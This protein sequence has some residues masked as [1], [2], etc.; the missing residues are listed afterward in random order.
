[1][2]N[3]L[4]PVKLGP[5]KGEEYRLARDSPG[6]YGD[7]RDRLLAGR[8][9]QELAI[10]DR[11]ELAES[12]IVHIHNSIFDPR[13]Y[14]NRVAQ[15]R[16]NHLL[17]ARPVRSSRE[18]AGGAGNGLRTFSSPRGGGVARCGRT[19]GPPALPARPRF[20]PGD[21]RRQGRNLFCVVEDYAQTV[22]LA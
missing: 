2:T 15:R 11:R 12:Q 17:A 4:V 9:R 6:V 14:S 18:P 22:T 13:S 20:R 7:A 16:Q 19:A 8:F 21:L 5:L 3:E 1:F 10:D